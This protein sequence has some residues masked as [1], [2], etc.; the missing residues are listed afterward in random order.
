MHTQF[1]QDEND[2]GKDVPNYSSAAACFWPRIMQT[3]VK[4]PEQRERKMVKEH[5]LC[6]TLRP[7]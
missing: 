2:D 1:A 4:E 3:E 6:P 7:G 5:S